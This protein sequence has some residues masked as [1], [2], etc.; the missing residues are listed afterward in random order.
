MGPGTAD[1]THAPWVRP[2]RGVRDDPT[3]R[4]EADAMGFYVAIA[5]LAALSTGNDHAAHTQWGVLQVVWG[6]TL[7]LALAHWFAVSLSARLVEDPTLHHSPAEMLAAQ[8]MVAL[9]VAA[10][11]T[12]VVVVLS[13]DNERLGARCTAAITIA[14]IVCYE[15]RRRGRSNGQALASGLAALAIGGT[16]AAAKW[17]VGR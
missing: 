14:V 4:R 16:V 11:A 10:I 5:L 15:L 13:A 7:G 17:F 1:T 12:V 3:L 6:T 8:V 9:V 2:W